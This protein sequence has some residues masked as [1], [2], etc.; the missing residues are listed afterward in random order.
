MW[1]N[2]NFYY[3]KSS[4]KL[5]KKHVDEYLSVNYRTVLTPKVSDKLKNLVLL[6]FNNIVK[7][8]TIF[9]IIKLC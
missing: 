5:L 6:F 3:I 4:N 8:I 1:D 2:F 7:Y 9:K